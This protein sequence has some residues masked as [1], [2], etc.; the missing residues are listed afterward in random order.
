MLLKVGTCVNGS[1]V[2]ISSWVVA[3]FDLLG[4]DTLGVMSRGESGLQGFISVWFAFLAALN[5]WLIFDWELNYSVHLHFIL[6]GF[7]IVVL[8]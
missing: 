1:F 4:V 6:Q 5:N 3:T 2:L 7:A 8:R